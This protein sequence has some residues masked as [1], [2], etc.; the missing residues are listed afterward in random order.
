[1][2]MGSHASVTERGWLK[3]GPHLAVVVCAVGL[4]R[5]ELRKWAMRENLA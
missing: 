4:A 3:D 5:V 2:T 1:M